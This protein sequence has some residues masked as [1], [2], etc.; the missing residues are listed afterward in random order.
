MVAIGFLVFHHIWFLGG[1]LFGNRC[2]TIGGFL[3]T[4]AVSFVAATCFW[5]I[6][7]EPPEDFRYD[8]R[9]WLFGCS[10]FTIV[11]GRVHTVA[12]GVE[13]RP[14]EAALVTR[15]VLSHAP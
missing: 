2:R 12:H 8:N 5:E 14:T 3:R 11:V 9:R 1:F 10:I 13:D 4:I 15:E 6:A 7:V